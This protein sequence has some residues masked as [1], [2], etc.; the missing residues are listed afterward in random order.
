[1]TT[2]N[3]MSSSDILYVIVFVDV[4]YEPLEGYSA[5]AAA[6]AHSVSASC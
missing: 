2:R 5:S 1:M 6:A 3:G 4:G